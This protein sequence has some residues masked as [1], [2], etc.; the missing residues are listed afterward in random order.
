MDVTAPPPPPPSEGAVE[1]SEA[2]SRPGQGESFKATHLDGELL[3]SEL[4][5]RFT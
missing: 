5:E 2:D 4:L 3:A 1:R